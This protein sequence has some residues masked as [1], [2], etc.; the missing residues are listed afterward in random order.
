MTTLT[1]GPTANYHPSRRLLALG[2][3][4][5]SLFLFALAISVYEV[6]ARYVFNAPTSW[7]NSTTTTLCGVAFALA[8]APVMERGEHIRIGSLVETFSVRGR[9]AAEV[10][11]LACGVLYLGG[12]TYASVIEAYE[13]VWRFDEGRW[14]P[15]P[16]PGPPGWPLPALLRVALA[17]GS[18]L[19]LWVTVKRL[20]ALMRGHQPSH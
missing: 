16:L 11:G 3:A 20:V 19:F 12:L 10:L 9:V 14:F 17:L 13:A 1:Q 15:E 7:V 8:G 6:I 18:L 2:D 4:T 5:S